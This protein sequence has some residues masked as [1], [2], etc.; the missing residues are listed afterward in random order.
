MRQRTGYK[1][2]GLLVAV[3]LTA[4]VML[5]EGYTLLV[6][7]GRHRPSWT[8]LTEG[9]ARGLY[10]VSTA[11]TLQWRVTFHRPDDP[12]G[13][14]G[15]VCGKTRTLGWPLRRMRY[16]RADELVKPAH[17]QSDRFSF[18]LR[19]DDVAIRIYA[20]RDGR[21]PYDDSLRY[22]DQ[23]QPLARIQYEAPYLFTM[24]M[25]RDSTAYFIHD[26]NGG[27]VGRGAV[28]HRGVVGWH[29][30]KLQGLYIGGT[31]PAPRPVRVTMQRLY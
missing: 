24:K 30:G 26:A 1:S 12:R 5:Q 22:A 23:S 20:Y 16:R 19:D 6:P 29:V 18:S 2:Y 10:G 9:W 15:K 4:S 7:E 17:E 13:I 28:Q 31:D 14:G 8:Q 27:Q 11:R 21:R 25:Y 3:M